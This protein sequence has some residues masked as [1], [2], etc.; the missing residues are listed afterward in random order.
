M[1]KKIYKYLYFLLTTLFPLAVVA[2]TSDS[3]VN[4]PEIMSNPEK[5]LL[6]DSITS[7]Y[8]PWSE[9]SIS[10]KLSAD[11]LPI[12]VSV[13]IYMEKDRLL[14]IS[15]SAPLIG[16][17]A[18]IEIDR[19]NAL[20]V[21]KMS[22]S[23]SQVAM[24]EIEPICPGGLSAMQNLILGRVDILGRGELNKSFAKEL[25][26]YRIESGDLLLLPNQDLENAPFIYYYTVDSLD[27]ILKTFTVMSQDGT[28]AICKY[29]GGNKNNT[30]TF[31]SVM[32]GKKMGATLKLNLPDAKAKKIDRIELDS[33]YKEVAKS[34]LLR[35]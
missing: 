25:E 12:S 2:Q 9:M 30:L 22:N 6:I 15:V 19:E 17:A 29:S 31:S 8:Y 28:Q 33:R 1:N 3:A 4:T 27:F 21:N 13:K 10:G 18:R 7:G 16:E 35:M 26:I 11:M 14:V 23:Y 24:E 34:K 20:V 5:E 32:N